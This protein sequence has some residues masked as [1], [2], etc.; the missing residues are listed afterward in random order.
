M[1][2]ATPVGQADF[3]GWIALCSWS[4][5][6]VARLLPADL[7]LAANVSLEDRSHPVVFLFGEQTEGATIFA[8]VTF[9]MGVRYHEFCVAI[10]FVIRGA[11]P[12]LHVYV[13]RMYSSYAPAT[14]AGNAHYGFGKETAAM[15][16]DDSTFVIT[17]EQGALVFHAMTEP[18]GDWAPAERCDSPGF[19][20]LES[21]FELPIVGR[22]HDGSY[23]TS[24]FRLDFRLAR[25]RAARAAL[26]I[27]APFVAGLRPGWRSS[28]PSATFEVERMV[29]GLSWPD[30][31]SD[32]SERASRRSRVS[33]PSV[34][35]S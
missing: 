17:D 28:L 3:N 30:H 27:D 11:D 12:A 35:R 9:P 22:R 31:R 5:T 23:V 16:S 21:V 26:S 19:A 6:E 18:A 25:V 10:P 32:K 7:E 20:S 2:A 8:G 33:K 4:R 13:P 15:R 14:W 29:W 34:N 1:D 24:H